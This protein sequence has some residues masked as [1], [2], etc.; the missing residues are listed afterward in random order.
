M[1]IIYVAKHDSGGNDDEDAIT[2]ALTKLGHD[3]QRVRE[4]VGHKATK[5]KGDL[6]LFHKWD[7]TDALDKFGATHIPR[8]FWYFD[9]VTW[10]WDPT[11]KGRNETRVS[12]MKRIIPRVELGFCTDGD[13]VE[14]DKTGK[15]VWLAQGADERIVEFSA[16]TKATYSKILF[17]GCSN[18]GKE[19]LEFISRMKSKYYE[20]FVHIERGTHREVLAKLTGSMAVTVAP[21]SPVT[22]RY[23]SNRVYNAI[24]FGAMVLHPY[25]RVLANN[26]YTDGVD[27]FYYKEMEELFDKIEFCLNHPR[28]STAIRLSGFARTLNEHLYIHRC[29]TLITTVK[30]RLGIK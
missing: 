24:G 10:P 9:L 5:M 19:R 14:A 3:V 26:H 13:W 11:L 15:L 29:E 4:S 23:W 22:D 2:Y 25:C 30:K 8:V 12:W 18:G 16:H 28:I 21:N 20:D 17:T 27:I 6:V 1:R 7:N